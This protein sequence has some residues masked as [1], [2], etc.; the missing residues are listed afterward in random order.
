MKQKTIEQEVKFEGIGL[1]SGERSCIVIHPEKEN[2]GIRFLIDGVYIPAHYTYV[3]NTNHSVDLGKDSKLIKT[4]EHLMAVFSLLGI[5]N[6]TVEFLKGYEVPIMDGSGYRFYKDLKDKVLELDDEREVLR[7]NR[8]VKVSQNGSSLRAQP[9]ENF[10]AI[11]VGYIETF[12]SHV[13][14]EYDGNVKDLIFAR[15]FCYDYQVDMLR[16]MGLAKGGS[17]EN[18]LVLGKGF[19]YNKEGMRSKDEPIRHKLFD[20]IGDLA[21]LGK[22]LIAYVISHRG[23]HRLNLLLVKEIAQSETSKAYLVPRCECN[24]KV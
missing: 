6:A 16:R 3:I 4:V 14:V 24:S 17:L 21:L 10:S 20:L 15:T 8:V 12:S 11:Y 9:S 7:L 18:V 13:V 5:D 2:T 19:V 23:G 22:H 1:H